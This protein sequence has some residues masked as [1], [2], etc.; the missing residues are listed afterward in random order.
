VEQLIAE[1]P[2]PPYTATLQKLRPGA[3]RVF[4][5]AVDDGGV[6]TDSDHHHIVVQGGI[7]GPR[8]T[9]MWM[10]PQTLMLTWDA[11][12][13]VL[14]TAEQVTGDW[15]SLPNAQSPHH[16]TPSGSPRYFRLRLPAQ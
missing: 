13:A 14:E 4:A 10:D 8:L 7:T 2:T 11:P 12:G 1:A 3:Y 9:I 5:R 6:S 16:V 15:I